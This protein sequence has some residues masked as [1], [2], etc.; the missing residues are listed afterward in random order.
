MTDTQQQI[1]EICDQIKELLLEKN[2]SYGDSALNPT[3]VFSKASTVEQLF[4]RI[5]DKLSRISR[6]NGLLDKD[7]DV[8]NDL[9]GYLVLTK[10]ALRRQGEGWDGSDIH[11]SYGQIWKTFDVLTGNGSKPSTLNDSEWFDMYASGD[12]FA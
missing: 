11:P 1:A 2:R 10:I 4:V 9:I 8:I 5:D 6:G 12:R 3:R 7:E